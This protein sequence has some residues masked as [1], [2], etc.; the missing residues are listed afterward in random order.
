MVPRCR[1]KCVRTC[2]NPPWNT[3]PKACVRTALQTSRR[4][5]PMTLPP[6]RPHYLM[7]GGRPQSFAACC[8]M[9]RWTKCVSADQFV[10]CYWFILWLL[11][12]EQYFPIRF[13]NCYIKKR[14]GDAR[15]NIAS[16]SNIAFFVAM[17][18]FIVV[19]TW[20]TVSNEETRKTR[21]WT[22]ERQETGH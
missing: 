2:L 5:W 11:R 19:I 18:T 14:F 7:S 4:R 20:D 10:F 17:V 8:E 13:C 6:P 3:E 9:K 1:L 16:R 22:L 21:N 15:C 12:M